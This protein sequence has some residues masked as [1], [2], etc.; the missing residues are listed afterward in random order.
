MQVLTLSVLSLLLATSSGDVELC[1]KCMCN[2][3]ALIQPLYTVRCSHL[4]LHDTFPDLQQWPKYAQLKGTRMAVNFDWNNV[5]HLQRFPNIPGI[6]SLSLQ[7]N[8]MVKIAGSAFVEL[9]NLKALDLSYNQLTEGVQA[10]VFQGRYSPQ[11]YNPLGIVVLNLGNNQIHT[12]S[13][14]SF[15][16]LPNLTE[17]RL[18]N[19]PLKTLSP[20]TLMSLAS[21]ESLQ[22]LDLA[23]TGLSG[24]PEEFVQL[25][26]IRHKL[27]LL[28]LN[29]NQFS[30]VPQTLAALGDSLQKLS[31]N[32][33][34][35]QELDEDSF[36]GLLMLRELNMSAMSYLRRIG[37]ATF[38]HLRSLEILFCSYNRNLTELDAEAFGYGDN[39][40]TLRE[41]HLQSNALHTLPT[42]LAP[43]KKLAIVDVQD[44][45]WRCDCNLD[46]FIN[47]LLPL[48]EDTT[49]DLVLGLHCSEPLHL[50]GMSFLGL[51]NSINSS[52]LCDGIVRSPSENIQR[53]SA[54]LY[55]VFQAV[56]IILLISIAGLAVLY[57]LQLT[58]NV[59]HG[60]QTQV[61]SDIP[62]MRVRTEVCREFAS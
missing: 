1:M 42:Q 30:H 5:R 11:H 50:S 6:V 61:I 48:L 44:N 20:A 2:K 45:P 25:S 14:H 52:F 55:P 38:R 18:N 7:H 24:L 27:Q 22:V 54:G 36:R 62:Y 35:I 21:P 3:K 28:Y 40:W 33:N 29:G 23:Y 56:S 10:D 4:N 49:P 41:L 60:T 15:E 57:Y 26:S 37:P 32:E 53:H 9:D 58:K 13:P 16:H 31:L 59:T 8:N 39:R 19:N 12:L 47:E 43:W 17:L 34:P 51:R 46:W